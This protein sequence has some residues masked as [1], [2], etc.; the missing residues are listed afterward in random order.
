MLLGARGSQV[1][2]V[3]A[4][5]GGAVD[6]VECADDGAAGRAKVRRSHVVGTVAR[7]RTFLLGTEEVLLVGVT[8]AALIGVVQG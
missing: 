1:L 8:G 2:R 6:V 5:V 4:H 7:D 3:V